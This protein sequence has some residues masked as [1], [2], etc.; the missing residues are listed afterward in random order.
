MIIKEC[1]HVI[2]ITPPANKIYYNTNQGV[3]QIGDPADIY[4][5]LKSSKI[6]F[7]HDRCSE[8]T[9][10]SEKRYMIYLDEIHG[11]VHIQ[12]FGAE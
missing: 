8:L 3:Y 11:L 10:R 5:K 6:P 1:L 4:N 7:V 9:N 2:G 12:S